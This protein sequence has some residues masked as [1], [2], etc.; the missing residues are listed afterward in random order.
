MQDLLI[1]A[2]G[3]AAGLL[4][5]ATSFGGMLIVPALAM[6]AGVPVHQGV[7][8]AMF[9][10]L[11]SGLAGTWIFSRKTVI[12]WA[13]ARWLVAGAIPGALAGALSLNLF[14]ARLLEILIGVVCFGA[15]VRSLLARGA[16]G[17]GVLPS[18][19]ALAGIGLAV[20]FGSAI[21]GTG[22]PVLLAPVLM[23]L[24]LPILAVIGLSQA[25]QVP[26]S[27]LATAGNAAVDL[28]HLGIGL[29]LMAGVLAGSVA[30]AHL[31]Q[32]VRTSTLTTLV[33]ALMIVIGLVFAARAVPS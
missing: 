1:L 9:S 14:D 21:T 24:Q 25:I 27:L 18:P 22:G 4:I 10:F 23:F 8:A 28:L 15:G 33:G 32:R 26:I 16:E 29:P 19:A 17:K 13:G 2:I 7:A 31:A 3:A 12:D 30:G 5:G 11:A 20:G 6:F